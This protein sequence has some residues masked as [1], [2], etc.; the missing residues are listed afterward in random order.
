MAL[1][2]PLRVLLQTPG[3]FS[4]SSM[5]GGIVQLLVQAICGRGQSVR[6]AILKDKTLGEFHLKVTQQKKQDRSNGWSK[7]RS[8]DK[9]THGAINVSW[10]SNT[11]V[12]LA[13]VITRG[14]G[15]LGVAKASVV[16]ADRFGQINALDPFKAPVGANTFRTVA[17]IEVRQL[18][19]VIDEID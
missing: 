9:G 14:G 17:T 6:D 2:L 5:G 1:G 4:L 10:D 12:L 7:V 3:R 11:H 15:D 18:R 16:D 19:E 8:T 13:R